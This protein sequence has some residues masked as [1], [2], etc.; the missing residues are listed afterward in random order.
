MAD[1]Y[2][3]KKMEAFQARKAKEQRAK[4]IAWKKRM[5][6]YRKRLEEQKASE[7]ASA[8]GV[9]ATGQEGSASQE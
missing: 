2:L 5:D 4:Q 9:C 3:E 7:A 8:D 6:A 1:N